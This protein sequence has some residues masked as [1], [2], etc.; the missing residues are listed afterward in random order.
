MS[1]ALI[2]GC[3]SGFGLLMAERFARH[4]DHVIA[5]VRDMRRCDELVA[6]R[7]QASLPI[8]LLPLD[9]RDAASIQVAVAAALDAGPLDVLINNAGYAL[10]CPVEEAGDGELQHLFDT[11]V[12][13]AARMIRAV[14]PAMRERRRGT[15]VNISSILAHVPRPFGGLYAASKAALSSMSE[16]LYL[17]LAP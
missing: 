3:S 4:G 9:V 13:G 17:E 11:N 8:T 1:N 12:F 2:T 14:A 5:T 16:A 7:D 15:I 10:R 6:L